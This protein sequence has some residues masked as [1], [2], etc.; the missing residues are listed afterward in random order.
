M[1]QNWIDVINQAS[2]DPLEA[3]AAT[4]LTPKHRDG[5]GRGCPMAALGPEIARQGPAARRAIT[6]ELRP[7]LNYL[8]RI[9]PGSST[10]L[11]RQRA[12]STYVSLVGA[13]V[14][15][16]VVDDPDLSNE[17]L[18]AVAAT[19]RNSVHERS[20]IQIPSKPRR[21]PVSKVRSNK[22]PSHPSKA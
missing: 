12:I 19:M 5:A 11:R 7:F 2:G 1:R 17:V 21:K 9:V 13:L 10:G 20:P 6:G 15:S 14:V 16:R 22:R 3:L 18:D 4:Y 8:S